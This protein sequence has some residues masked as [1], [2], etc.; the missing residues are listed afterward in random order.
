MGNAWG[1]LVDS[2]PADG[3]PFGQQAEALIDVVGEV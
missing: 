2:V 1:Y 3:T